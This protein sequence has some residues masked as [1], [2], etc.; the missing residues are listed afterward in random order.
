MSS[1]VLKIP[2]ES[3]SFRAALAKLRERQSPVVFR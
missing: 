1:I 3:Q 2:I